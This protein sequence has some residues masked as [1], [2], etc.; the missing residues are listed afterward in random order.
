MHAVEATHVDMF[1]NLRDRVQQLRLK[2]HRLQSSSTYD[3]VLASCPELGRRSPSRRMAMWWRAQGVGHSGQSTW[4]LDDLRTMRFAP[5]LRDHHEREEAGGVPPIWSSSRTSSSG[6]WRTAD[7]PR[8]EG[9]DG[10]HLQRQVHGDRGTLPTAGRKLPKASPTTSPTTIP[11]GPAPLTAPPTIPGATAKARMHPT[12][13]KAKS[14]DE[15]QGEEDRGGHRD[16]D[17][18][19]LAQAHDRTGRDRATPEPTGGTEVR[20]CGG[21]GPSLQCGRGC[22]DARVWFKTD[23]DEEEEAP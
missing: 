6:N 22:R 15:R 20:H 10:G 18:P 1:Q 17:G 5:E 14:K 12:A 13:A 11:H 8:C 4:P 3:G 23:Q 19:D 7:D 21:D 2:L 9:H 16:G